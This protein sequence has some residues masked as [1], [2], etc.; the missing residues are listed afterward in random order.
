MRGR[1]QS[2][3]QSF[4]GLLGLYEEFVRLIKKLRGVLSARFDVF[5]V[6]ALN[7]DVSKG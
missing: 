3:F 1:N 2:D 4:E 5:E 6:Q 7:L